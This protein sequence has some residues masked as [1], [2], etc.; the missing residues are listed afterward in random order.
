MYCVCRVGG[1]HNSGAWGKRPRARAKGVLPSSNSYSRKSEREA[2]APLCFFEF[3]ETV[4]VA[5]PSVSLIKILYPPSHYHFFIYLFLPLS[6]IINTNATI[7][8]NPRKIPT[9]RIIL[10]DGLSVT[11]GTYSASVAQRLMSLR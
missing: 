1:R 6:W 9:E 3:R 10:S 8:D 7:K 2:E 11:F 5:A 4:R